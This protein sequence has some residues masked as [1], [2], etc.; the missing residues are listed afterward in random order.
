MDSDWI[1]LEFKHNKQISDMDQNN[2]CVLGLSM[3]L[4]RILQNIII[5]ADIVCKG[6]G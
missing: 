5:V 4:F 1:C 2:S 3:I 6:Y